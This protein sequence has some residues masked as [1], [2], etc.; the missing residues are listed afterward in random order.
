VTPETEVETDEYD[1]ETEEVEEPLQQYV[2]PAQDVQTYVKFLGIT[3]N[4][5][6]RR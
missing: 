4:S 1:E 3:D 2:M 6:W 5:Q